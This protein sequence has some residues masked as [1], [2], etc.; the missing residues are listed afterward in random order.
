MLDTPRFSKMIVRVVK[1]KKFDYRYLLKYFGWKLKS[2]IHISVL[3]EYFQNTII[4][5][6]IV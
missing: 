3:R 6:A 1:F 4:S 2:R 5:L